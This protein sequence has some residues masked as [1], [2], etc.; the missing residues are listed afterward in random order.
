MVRPST[1][2]SL[3]KT[4]GFVLFSKPV[5]T[6]HGV[7][8][9]EVTVESLFLTMYS[10]CHKENSGKFDSFSIDFQIQLDS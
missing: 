9:P 1:P 5:P 8:A 3:R 7:F 4:G 6:I 10:L 2:H